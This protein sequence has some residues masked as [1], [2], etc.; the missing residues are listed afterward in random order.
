MRLRSIADFVHRL[1]ASL[2]F[3]L[4]GLGPGFAT[5]FPLPISICDSLQLPAVDIVRLRSTDLEMAEPAESWPGQLTA[6]R[7]DW[8]LRSPAETKGPDLTQT[9]SR[10]GGQSL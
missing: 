5:T 1:I 8:F 7:R 6:G 3:M 10:V 4:A 9:H 2:Q